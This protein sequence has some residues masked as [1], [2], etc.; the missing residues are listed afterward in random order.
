M[1]KAK[2]QVEVPEWPK[3]LA[4]PERA[5]PQPKDADAQAN[6]QAPPMTAFFFGLTRKGLHLAAEVEVEDMRLVGLTPLCASRYPEHASRVWESLAFYRLCHQ[7]KYTPAEVKGNELEGA[8]VAL[9]DVAEGSAIAL[10]PR[11]GMTVA[12]V[13]DVEGTTVTEAKVI[14]TGDRLTAWQAAHSYAQRGFLP[15]R[16]RP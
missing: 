8:G 9:E 1:S 12:L 11:P 5:V 6:K 15:R 10:A 16:M 14:G 3:S 7:R 2:R 4:L 13:L